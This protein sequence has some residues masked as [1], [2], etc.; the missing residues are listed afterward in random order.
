MIVN[1]SF[2]GHVGLLLKRSFHSLDAPLV[3][4]ESKVGNALLVEHLRIR[5][6]NR[7]RPLQVIYRKLVLL[8]VEV[9][10]GT[11]FQKFDVVVLRLDR[12]VEMLNR[13]V[14][15]AQSVVAT[16]KAI[17]H[18]WVVFEQ[19]TL[20]EVLDSLAHQTRFQF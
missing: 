20:L 10:L 4:F 2:V 12:F 3:L 9:A 18:C 17:V 6:L 11:I 16:A 19:L 14:E 1:I 13:L 15:V 7:K 8:H 5:V